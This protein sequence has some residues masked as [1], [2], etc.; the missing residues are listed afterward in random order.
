MQEIF[1]LKIDLQLLQ[2]GA[3]LQFILDLNCLNEAIDSF[4]DFA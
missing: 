2:R 3:L 1:V 4:R